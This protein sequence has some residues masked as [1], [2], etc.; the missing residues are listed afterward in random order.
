[1]LA[2]TETDQSGVRPTL[3]LGSQSPAWKWPQ[4]QFV[5][6]QEYPEW[7]L[8]ARPLAP[9]TRAENQSPGSL[10]S[11]GTK[12]ELPLDGCQPIGAE[13][14]AVMS[15][16]S[17]H[18]SE[19]DSNPVVAQQKANDRRLATKPTNAVAD[20]VAA[21]LSVE[22]RGHFIKDDIAKCADHQVQPPVVKVHA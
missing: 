22:Q 8:V 4:P 10:G 20:L 13:I 7:Q 12:N 3:R 17:A 2:G 19:Q 18:L 9:T 16:Q 11:V 21:M 5:R 6:S 1:M 15:A 14:S